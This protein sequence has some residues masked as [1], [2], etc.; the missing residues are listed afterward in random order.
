[1]YMYM[2]LYMY[3]YI[4]T[5]IAWG[6]VKN[7]TFLMINLIKN[8]KSVNNKT[9]KTKPFTT[10][11]KEKWNET[12]ILTRTTQNPVGQTLKNRRWKNMMIWDREILTQ[13]CLLSILWLSCWNVSRLRG[14]LQQLIHRSSFVVARSSSITLQLH[15]SILHFHTLRFHQEKN[16]SERNTVIFALRSGSLLLDFGFYVL[17]WLSNIPTLQ[18]SYDRPEAYLQKKNFCEN[19]EN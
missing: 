14:I 5:Y 4:C 9:P 15:R 2:C 18:L 12:L 16:S 19:N 17:L 11:S 8:C 10:S 13:C 6:N 1:M 3:T 7:G